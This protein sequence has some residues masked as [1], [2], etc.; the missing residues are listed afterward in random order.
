MLDGYSR[1]IVHHELREAKTERH[2]E[3]VVQRPLE[4]FPVKIR[5][6]SPTTAHSSTARDFKSFVRL[7]GMAHVQTSP[8]HP[9]S[10]G[11]LQRF[12]GSLKR[13]GLRPCCPGSVDEAR[14]QVVE[15][16]EHY[17]L[18]RLHSAIGYATPADKL[19]VL[20]QAI[21]TERDRKLEQARQ[22]RAR[23][24]RAVA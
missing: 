20:E 17:N 19:N 18:L 10:N 2:T 8:Y 7:V 24:R 9:Q 4:N 5:G 23:H 11:Q 3:L 22:Q 21:F 12:H 1:D 14:R 16:V 15:Y 6:S 13:E